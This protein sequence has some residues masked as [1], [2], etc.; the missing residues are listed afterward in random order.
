MPWR[1]AV[2]VMMLTTFSCRFELLECHWQLYFRLLS[3]W[4]KLWGKHLRGQ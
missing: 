2:K 1:H 4:V 3:L